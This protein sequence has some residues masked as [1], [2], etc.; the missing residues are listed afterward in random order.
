[1]VNLDYNNM[2]TAEQRRQLNNKRNVKIKI[3]YPFVYERHYSK[4]PEGKMT[5]MRWVLLVSLEIIR[6]G[7]PVGSF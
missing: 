2:S 1:M 5:H 7:F 4:N 3:R 6:N